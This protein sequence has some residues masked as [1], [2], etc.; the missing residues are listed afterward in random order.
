MKGFLFKYDFIK[1]EV[2]YIV[3]FEFEGKITTMVLEEH[4]LLA[5]D[6]MGHFVKI[7]YDF[8]NAK[9]IKP[10]STYQPRN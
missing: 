3:K 4:F 2:F 7:A 1:E 5:W 8:D 6:N 10:K 9:K